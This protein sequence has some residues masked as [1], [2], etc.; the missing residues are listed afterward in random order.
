MNRIRVPRYVS[1][2]MSRKQIHVFS[3]ASEKA[4]GAAIYIHSSNDTGHVRVRLLCS[5]SKVAPLKVQTLSRLELAGAKLA[6]ELSK[7]VQKAVGI[8]SDQNFYW[9]DS[10]I[11]LSWLSRL[12]RRH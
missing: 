8:G 3:D 12:S 11:T 4:Y 10:K 7:R 1:V 2:P 6:A 9:T 5:K